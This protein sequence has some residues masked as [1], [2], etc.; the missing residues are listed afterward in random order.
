VLTNIPR[1][2]QLGGKKKIADANSP[3]A[4]FLHME[5]YSVFHSNHIQNTS[6][7]GKKMSKHALRNALCVLLLSGE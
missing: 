1:G 6:S 3:I 4:T 7:Q 2:E 5:T